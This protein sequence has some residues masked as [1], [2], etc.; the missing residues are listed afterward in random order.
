MKD[1]VAHLIALLL[2]S[3]FFGNDGISRKLPIKI[4]KTLDSEDKLKYYRH[5]FLN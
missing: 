2:K 5:N 1:D 4:V 3:S